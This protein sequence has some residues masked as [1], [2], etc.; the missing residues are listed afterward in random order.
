VGRSAQDVL[1]GRGDQ[2]GQDEQRLLW[3]PLGG[4]P[5]DLAS[6]FRP[7]LRFAHN[8]EADVL[9]TVEQHEVRTLF[10]RFAFTS[11]PHIE[12]GAGAKNPQRLIPEGSSLFH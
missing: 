7:D 11:Q 8:Q 6:S 12:Q 4:P 2:P 5:N 9:V 1:R 10:T 3:F